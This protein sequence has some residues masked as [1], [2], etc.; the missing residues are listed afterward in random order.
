MTRDTLP[1]WITGPNR[2]PRNPH[3]PLIMRVGPQGFEPWTKGL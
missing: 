2:K 3:H 1:G